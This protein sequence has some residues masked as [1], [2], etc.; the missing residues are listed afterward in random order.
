MS[1]MLAHEPD[2][3]FDQVYLD[4]MDRNARDLIGLFAREMMRAN[5]QAMTDFSARH[6]ATV[7]ALL[8]GARQ[9]RQALTRVG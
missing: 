8:V 7:H 9:A 1:A 3:Q 5:S 2:K 4:V 6:I